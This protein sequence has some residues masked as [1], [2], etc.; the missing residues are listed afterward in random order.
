MRS[1]DL[2]SLLTEFDIAEKSEK[3]VSHSIMINAPATSFEFAAS[4]ICA[5][6]YTFEKFPLY[7]SFVTAWKLFDD[8]MA[9]AHSANVASAMI[10]NVFMVS[11]LSQ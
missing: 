9:T 8:G 6:S 3:H 10:I 2:I 7:Q 4:R 5:N 11:F 1:A